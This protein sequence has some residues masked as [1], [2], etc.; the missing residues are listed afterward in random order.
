MMESMR[1]TTTSKTSWASG[2]FSLLKR[3]LRTGPSGQPDRRF[4][5]RLQMHFEAKILRESGWMRVRGVDLHTE[6]AMFVAS[7]P[8]APQSVVFVHLKSLGL[9]GFAHVRHCTER[10]LWG[11]T[12]GMS[13]PAPLM[14][15]ELGPWQIHR[16]RQTD[17]AGA[18]GERPD[19]RLPALAN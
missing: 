3:C 4:N 16:V 10:G 8:L 19:G 5:H 15:A 13:F 2:A 11:Y 7:R 9:M 17:G 12:I 18:A 14:K 1:P 6:G